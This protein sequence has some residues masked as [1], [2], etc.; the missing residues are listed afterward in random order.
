VPITR[1]CAR[2]VVFR[3]AATALVYQK[4]AQ[5][6]MNEKT[7]DAHNKQE[8]GFVKSLFDAS[9]KINPHY[10]N[11]YWGIGE[12]N[13]KER[14]YKEAE[15]ALK[16]TIALEPD[17]F[18]AYFSLGRVYYKSGDRRNGLSSFIKAAQISPGNEIL[19]QKVIRFYE[20]MLEFRADRDV[21]ENEY[22]KVSINE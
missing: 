10:A 19:K 21:F 16:K 15:K 17:H 4:L 3:K 14:K 11:A 12:L 5:A 7:F 20:D 6:K 18:D 13:L 2:L 22:K 1:K 9:L 8:A